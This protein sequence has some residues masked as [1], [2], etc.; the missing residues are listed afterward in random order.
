MLVRHD[1][2]AAMIHSLSLQRRSAG[3]Q[4]G[5]LLHTAN[6]C[7][8]ALLKVCYTLNPAADISHRQSLGDAAYMPAIEV[9]YADRMVL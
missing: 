5:I 1:P 3:A 8:A 7:H 9:P 6:I 2:T 4:G